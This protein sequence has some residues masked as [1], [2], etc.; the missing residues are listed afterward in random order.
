MAVKLSQ[1]P[2][3][4]QDARRCV[5]FRRTQ[6]FVQM[7]GVVW[8]NGSL[9][10]ARGRAAGSWAEKREFKKQGATGGG[11]QTPSHLSAPALRR[12]WVWRPG[13]RPTDLLQAATRWHAKSRD[14]RLIR[15][16]TN[17]SDFWVPLSQTFKTFSKTGVG[18][19]TARNG[20]P[21]ALRWQ[22]VHSLPHSTYAEPKHQICVEDHG[23][24]LV[25]QLEFP[26]TSVEFFSA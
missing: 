7:A 23:T 8:R 24:F 9:P 5:E 22:R 18:H 13:L 2:S 25:V 21:R 11:G 26:I 6:R 17:L 15:L 3:V 19:Q 14:T 1:N 4:F 10:W 20:M 16:G 12:L